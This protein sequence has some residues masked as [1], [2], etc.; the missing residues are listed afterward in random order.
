MLDKIDFKGGIPTLG[1]HNPPKLKVH[2]LPVSVR[3]DII[4]SGTGKKD[5]KYI[6]AIKLQLS[7]SNAF[8][9]EMS[10]YVSAV[11]QGYCKVYM[12]ADEAIVYAPYCQIIDVG[13]SNVFEGVK[14]ITSRLKEVDAACHNIIDL[15][16]SI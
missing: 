14:S 7:M 13:S 12:S 3:P 15:W 5:K 1:H 8:D 11:L 4:L 9:D 16:P 10:G 6:G 2:N